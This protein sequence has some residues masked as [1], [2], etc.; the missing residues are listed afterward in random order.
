[1]YY[2][3]QIPNVTHTVTDT[4]TICNFLK[5]NSSLYIKEMKQFENKI[6]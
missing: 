4:M 3:I 1:M 2:A 6:L 5:L